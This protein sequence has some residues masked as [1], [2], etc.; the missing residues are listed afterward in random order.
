VRRNRR[1]GSELQRPKA[2][3]W[4][5]DIQRAITSR[6]TIDVAYVGNHG[7]DEF[8]QVDLNAPPLAQGDAARVATCAAQSISNAAAAA[9]SAAATAFKAACSPD[10]TAIAKARPYNT[11]FPYLNFIERSTG[12]AGIFSNYNALQ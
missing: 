2:I 7:Y 9:P 10:A 8:S 6:L 1:T 5:V 11:K 4:N 3:E 12:S